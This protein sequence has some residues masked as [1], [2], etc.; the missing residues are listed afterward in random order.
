MAPSTLRERIKK[1]GLE[2]YG[3]DPVTATDP[4]QID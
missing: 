3:S 4:L 2:G 1:Y